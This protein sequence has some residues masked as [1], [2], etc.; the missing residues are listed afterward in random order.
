MGIPE[1]K[2][3]G[4][5]YAL[6]RFERYIKGP[7][8]DQVSPVAPPASTANK[9][10]TPAAMLMPFMAPASFG[11]LPLAPFRNYVLNAMFL[12]SHLSKTSMRRRSQLN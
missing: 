7:P 1:K 12:T 2:A 5:I 3:V 11:G 8:E 6:K 10:V 4:L 9:N